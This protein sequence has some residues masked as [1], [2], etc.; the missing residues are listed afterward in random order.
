MPA[1]TAS[2]AAAVGAR[3]LEVPGLAVVDRLECREPGERQL[4]IPP[5]D[6]PRVGPEERQ[7]GE[8]FTADDIA[9]VG[10]GGDPYGEPGGRTGVTGIAAIGTRI[11]VISTT[12]T[13]EP[14]VGLL[15][16]RS[17]SARFAREPLWSSIAPITTTIIQTLMCGM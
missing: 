13:G 7:V 14:S 2:D 4:D 3:G 5:E 10:R 12:T 11:I 8:V 1:P 9:T 17:S 16:R 15:A 6:T